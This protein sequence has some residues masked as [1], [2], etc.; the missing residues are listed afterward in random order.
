[1][2][3]PVH[4]QLTP[5]RHQNWFAY[6]PEDY[7][8]SAAVAGMLGTAQFGGAEVSEVDRVGRRLRSWIGD[9]QAWFA[10][11]GAEA[12]RLQ[13][14]AVEAEAAGRRLTAAGLHLRACCYLQMGERFRIPKPK[15][16]STRTG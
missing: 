4:V 6:F 9:D 14:L 1:M 8:W 5:P 3:Q 10:E 11:W 16:L 12:G 7:R 13:G 15:F 2:T